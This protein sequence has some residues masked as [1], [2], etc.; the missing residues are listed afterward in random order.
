MRKSNTSLFIIH[1]EK[2]RMVS[3]LFMIICVLIEEIMLAELE[4]LYNHAKH[5]FL[6]GYLKRVL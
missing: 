5:Y 2:K 3:E 1:I 4:L 6:K